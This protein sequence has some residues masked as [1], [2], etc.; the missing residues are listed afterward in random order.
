MRG[1]TERCAFV[2]KFVFILGISLFFGRIASKGAV[3]AKA[4]A[5]TGNEGSVRLSEQKYQEPEI[6]ITMTGTQDPD[7]KYY[8]RADNCG[9]VVVFSGGAELRTSS[10]RVWI[11]EKEVLPEN[12]GSSRTSGTNRNEIRARITSIENPS[13]SENGGS[14]QIVWTIPAAEIRRL[15]D[16]THSVF[17]YAEDAEGN[18]MMPD[19]ATAPNDLRQPADYVNREQSEHHAFIQVRGAAVRGGAAEFVLDQT[20]PVCILSF[21]AGEAA[22]KELRPEGERFYL[23]H[24]F[25]MTAKVQD[26]NLREDLLV[27]RRGSRTE[28]AY[29]ADEVNIDEYP[30]IIRPK[31]ITE[32]TF[33]FSDIPSRDGVYRY[34]F[35]GYDKAG[36]E[37]VVQNGETP[38]YRS[39][40]EYAEDARVERREADVSE[41]ARV[42]RREDDVFEAVRAERREADVSEDARVERREADVSENVRAERMDVEAARTEAETISFYKSRIFVLDTTAP[43]GRIFLDGEECFTN[44]HLPLMNRRAD[45]IGITLSVDEE[46]EHSPVK[47]ECEVRALPAHLSESM[48]TGEYQNGAFLALYR[49]GRQ[50]FILSPC[51]FTDLAGNQTILDMPQAISLDQDAPVIE[52]FTASHADGRQGGILPGFSVSGGVQSTEGENGYGQVPVFSGE[53]LLT[54]IIT[55]P[56][57]DEGCSGL[58][59]ARIEICQDGKPVLSGQF[60]SFGDRGNGTGTV[61]SLGE[62]GEGTGTVD[63]SGERGD[64]KADD[65]T[66]NAAPSAAPALP[67]DKAEVQFRVP[68]S[69][70]SNDLLAVITVRD[71]AGNEVSRELAFAIDVTPPEAAVS[72]DDQAA[73]NGKY[74]P[75]E[76]SAVITVTEKNFSPDLA[77]LRVK[78]AVAD[79]AQNSALLHEK[80][81]AARSGDEI[82]GRRSLHENVIE[83]ALWSKSAD[84]PDTWET[85]VHFAEE[86]Y[87]TLELSVSD[88]A[89]NEAADIRYDGAAARAFVIDRTPPEVKIT[90]SGGEALNGFYYN[91]ARTAKIEVSDANFAGEH[92]FGTHSFSFAITGDGGTAEAVFSEDGTYLLEG[93]VTDLAGNESPLVSSGVFVIDTIPPTITISGV[94]DGSANRDPVDIVLAMEDANADAGTFTA[95]LTAA[96]EE[97]SRTYECSQTNQAEWERTL[98]GEDAEWER[99]LKGEDAEWE[100]T[101]KK[102]D[103]P[104]ADTGDES[105]EDRRTEVKNVIHIGTIDTDDLYDLTA[106]ASDLAGNRAEKIITFSEN[107]HGTVFEF[108]QDEVKDHYVNYGIRPS[109]ILH[110]V[111]DVN[112]LSVTVNGEEVPYD[113]EN[114]RLIYR[115]ELHIDGKYI[116]GIETEDSAGNQNAMQPVEFMI[117]TEPPEVLIT[118]LTPGK[119]YYTEEIEVTLRPDSETAFMGEVTLDG[120]VCEKMADGSIAVKIADYGEH[121]LS[122]YAEDLAGNRT[123]EQ[124]YHFVLRK[125][126]LYRWYSNPILYIVTF[127]LLAGAA[128]WGVMRLKRTD[129]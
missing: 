89:G 93:T 48:D 68:D 120:H 64:G 121:T 81:A 73:R 104:A 119:K 66:G 7:G 71:Q 124:T 100:R 129:I 17:A 46:T 30:E 28:G 3:P 128:V 98:K 57:P 117:D 47:I 63:S 107:Q 88:P 5:R 92:T 9:I 96:G 59:E 37:L 56:F 15:A 69:L 12:E 62:R 76:R 67:A 16:G 75:A 34:A 85:E 78:R 41:D 33:L 22:R 80:Q 8:Y 43:L 125:S 35:C 31:R 94:R 29:K 118:G 122:Y 6:S 115:D 42:E 99:T 102:E 127:M 90:F 1:L 110:N 45:E 10:C 49:S 2:M 111:N 123:P 39:G 114:G 38:S 106:E 20:P 65:D 26:D 87:Y 77:Q 79:A 61:G 97:T 13:F 40:K 51:R 21:D 74:F 32:N 72:F 84:D 53:V 91:A 18:P 52:S 83:H 105:G 101:L 50:A 70:E 55:D 25:A 54:A 60:D 112:V 4:D 103:I 86:G 116:L 11:D 14:K 109:F 113:Y 44:G 19:S 24:A 82:A 36:N 126:F 58:L 27:F 108:E 23:N 95:V